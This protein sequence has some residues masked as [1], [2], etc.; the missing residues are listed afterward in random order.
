MTETRRSYCGLCHPRCGLRLEI[1]NGKAVKATGDPDHP[2]TR[3]RICIRV[4]AHL[5]DILHPRMADVQHGWWFP[6]RS[7]A[8]PDLFGVFESNANVLCPDRPEFC[9]P[10][11][12]GWPHSALLCRVEKLR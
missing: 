3:G 11:I 5:T 4:K 7:G 12:G 2:V 10:E 8:E 9:I 6:E 1:E